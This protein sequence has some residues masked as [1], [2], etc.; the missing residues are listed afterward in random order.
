MT[1][2]LSNTVQLRLLENYSVMLELLESLLCCLGSALL[3][4]PPFSFLFLEFCFLSAC[5]KDVLLKLRVS[6]LT[7]SGLLKDRILFSI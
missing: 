1:V 3:F 7:E 5:N 2:G 6:S 4:F